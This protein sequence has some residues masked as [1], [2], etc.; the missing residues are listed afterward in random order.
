MLQVGVAG[1]SG[2][3]GQALWDA[4]ALRGDC[5]IVC[6]IAMPGTK[7]PSGCEV[8]CTDDP[9]SLTVIPRVFVDFSRPECT[10]RL[11]PWCVERKVGLVI[12]TT[13]FTPEQH[14]QIESAAAQIPLVMAA[15]F[16]VGVNILL[17]LVKKTA[18]VMDAADI[19]IVEAHHRHKVDA[20]SGTALSLGRAA[21]AGR[22]ADF[23]EVAVL[24]REGIVGERKAGS[25]GFAAVRGGDIVG[26]HNVMFCAEGERVELKHVATSRLTFAGGALRAAQF[27]AEQKPGL[28][29]FA[30]VLGLE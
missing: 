30:A 23:D 4:A 14:A 28:Y 3:M 1:L 13:G 29:S 15:N 6:G 25:I 24:S 16:S 21:A 22:G 18:A 2:R 17:S 9:Q 11:L 10:L 27:V 7:L 19:E 8:P 20:P 5:Q 26:E 12:G